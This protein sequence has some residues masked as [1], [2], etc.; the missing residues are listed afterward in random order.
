MEFG[1][2]AYG[3]HYFGLHMYMVVAF[4]LDYT[5]IYGYWCCWSNKILDL[6]SKKIIFDL[7][8]K[9]TLK[10]LTSSLCCKPKTWRSSFLFFSFLS[11][12]FSLLLSYKDSFGGKKIFW[13]GNMQF[14]PSLFWFWALYYA[15]L[16][17]DF[18]QVSFPHSFSMYYAH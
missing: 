13:R 11:I 3:L 1:A 8:S 5:C 7:F 9:R 10:F 18:P 16:A 2:F 17:F 14:S 15:Y 12:L 6:I 4:S